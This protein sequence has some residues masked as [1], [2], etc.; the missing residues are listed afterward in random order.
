[1]TTLFPRKPARRSVAQLR[2]E[3]WAAD[4]AVLSALLDDADALI[5]RASWSDLRAG[6]ADADAGSGWSYSIAD[7]VATLPIHGPLLASVPWWA[8]LLGVEA[9]GY[10]DLAAALDDVAHRDDVESIVLDVDSPGGQVRGLVPV[11]DAIAASAKPVT[12][13]VRTAASAAY[14]LA[15]QASAI[16]IERGGEAGSIGVYATLADSSRMAEGAGLRVLVARSGQHK[17]VGEAGVPISDEQFAEVQRRVDEMAAEF[18]AAV[19]RGRGLDADAASALADGRV[20]GS[21]DAVRLGLADRVIS[22][23]AG[24]QEATRVSNESNNSL[25][26]QAYEAQ[27]AEIRAA[28][29]TATARATA[30]EQALHEVRAAQ[31]A[32]IVESGVKAGVISPAMRPAVEAFAAKASPDELRAFVAS[33]PQVTRPTLEGAADKGEPKGTQITDDVKRVAR[34]FGADPASVAARLESLG[35]TR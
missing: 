27:I 12:A 10:D 29:E 33:L 7:G 9:T 17:G 25:G 34:M 35:G 13:R 5:A 31:R 21:E 11:A 16:E 1:V 2:R 26:A 32:E 23:H 30:A 14:W 4:E 24:A 18:V 20:F 8:S 28:L 6:L 15:S 19:V 22:A 3:L